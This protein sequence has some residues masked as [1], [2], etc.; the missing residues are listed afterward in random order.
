MKNWPL[1]LNLVALVFSSGLLSQH[2]SQGFTLATSCWLV[3]TGL[4]YAVLDHA[5]SQRT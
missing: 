3:A 1:C 2:L 4:N 5:L